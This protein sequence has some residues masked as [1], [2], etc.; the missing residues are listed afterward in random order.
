MAFTPTL[1]TYVISLHFP[2]DVNAIISSAVKAISE[3]TG[4]TFI[5]KNKIPPHVTIGAF[6]A[7]KED[8]AKLLNIKEDFSKNLAKRMSTGSVTGDVS[9]NASTPSSFAIASASRFVLPVFV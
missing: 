2:P 6:H 7:A 1:T 5:L 8:E 4:N 9:G 3:L